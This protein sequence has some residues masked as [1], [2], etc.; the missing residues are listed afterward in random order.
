MCVHQETA[1]QCSQVSLPACCTAADRSSFAGLL[2]QRKALVDS[3]SSEL[4]DLQGRLAQGDRQ[5]SDLLTTAADHQQRAG[6]LQ[7]ELAGVNEAIQAVEEETAAWGAAD[8]AGS[9]QLQQH[10]DDLEASTSQIR[11]VQVR[12][13]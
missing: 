5:A 2:L 6:A 1:R 11:E 12:R 8:A 10:Q 3:Y 7:A 4:S 13:Y 9:P